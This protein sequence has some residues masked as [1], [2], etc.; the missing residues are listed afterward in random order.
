MKSYTIIR[1]PNI[2]DWTKIPFAKIDIQL[3]DTP[4]DISATGQLCYDDEFLYVRLTAREKNIRAEYTGPLDPP[5]EDSCLEF[6]FC[7]IYGDDRY[8]N[9]EYNPNCC[10]YLGIGSG[11]NDLVRLIPESGIPF[12]PNV[13]RTDCR[14]EITYQIP[15]EFIRRFFPD[16]TPVS[17][18]KMYG[19]FYKCGDLTVTEHY[20]CWNKINANPVSFHRPCDFGILKFE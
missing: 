8:F 10:I 4:V 20:L 5:C 16:F 2:L 17:G 9:I 1:K 6:F 12:F 3:Q 7:P 14:W 13:V 18:T 19:N 15:F 11:I